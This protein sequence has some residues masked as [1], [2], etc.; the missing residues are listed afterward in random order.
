[1]KLLHI[2]KLK[3]YEYIPGFTI[4]VAVFLSIITGFQSFAWITIFYWSVFRADLVPVSLLFGMGLIYDSL[5]SYYLG[6]EAFIYLVL[7]TIVNTDRRFLLRKDFMYLWLSICSLMFVGFVGKYLL[8][9]PLGFQVSAYYQVLDFI[10]GSLT[11]P[12]LIRVL[13]PVYR[14]FA[15]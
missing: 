11:F 4:I 3:I 15:I 8:A 12:I 6:L 1:M 14:R 13:T 9:M 7:M 2:H 5:C 10:V